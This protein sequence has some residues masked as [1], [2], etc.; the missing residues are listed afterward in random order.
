MKINEPNSPYKGL[1]TENWKNKTLELIEEHP[2]KPKEISEVVRKAW[3]DI[4]LSTIGSR[5]FR[6]GSDLFPQP[7]IM[8]FFLH[9]LIAL[10]FSCRYPGIWR[11]EETSDEKDMVCIPDALYSIEIKTSSSPRN[12]FGNRSYAQKTSASKK[13]KSGY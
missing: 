2:L 4:F 8:G 5:P 1:D 11:R 12:I 6:I 10:E 9:E 3:D 7:Q 13:S